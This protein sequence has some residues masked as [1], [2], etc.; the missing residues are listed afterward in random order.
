MKNGK[1]FFN[2]Y[3][4]NSIINNEVQLVYLM[5]KTSVP[6]ETKQSMMKFKSDIRRQKIKNFIFP[7]LHTTRISINSGHDLA[8]SKVKFGSE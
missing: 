8:Q 4:T 1:T 6:L 7:G 5:Y 2:A 3:R